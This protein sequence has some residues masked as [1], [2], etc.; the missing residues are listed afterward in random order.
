MFMCNFPSHDRLRSALFFQLAAVAIGFGG[1]ICLCDASL[2]G[3]REPHN[4]LAHATMIRVGEQGIGGLT[5]TNDASFWRVP[6]VDAGDLIFAWVDSRPSPEVNGVAADSFLT[7]LDDSGNPLEFDDNDGPGRSSVIAGL[8]APRSG[9][10]FYRVSQI[11][12]THALVQFAIHHALVNPA[13]SA[14][15]R[16]P[17]DTPAQ[18]E[19]I[20]SKITTGTAGSS[21]VID[22]DHFR[23][24]V[25][26]GDDV[27]VI[28]DADPDQDGI[29]GRFILDIAS[30][31]GATLLAR[32]DGTLLNDANAVGPVE[33]QADGPLLVRIK[34]L[35]DNTGEPLDHDYRF[36]V[37]VR[38]RVYVDSDEDGLENVR[39][40]CPSSPNPDQRDQDGDRTGDA[41]D[42]CPNSPLKSDPGECGCDRPDVDIDGDGQFDCVDD[43]ARVLMDRTGVFIMPSSLQGDFSAYDARDG[44]L[45]D[46]DFLGDTAGIANISG[47]AFDPLHRRLIAISRGDRLVQIGLEDRSHEFFTP[48]GAPEGL[49]FDDAKGVIVLPD[50][51]VLVASTGGPNGNAIVELDGGGQLIQ[52]RVPSGSE[53]TQPVDLLSSPTELLVSDRS[54]GRIARFDIQ[55]GAGLSDLASVSGLLNRLSRR[56][57]GNLLAAVSNG[58][59]RGII[60]FSADG[61]RLLHLAPHGISFF[62][63]AVELADQSQLVSAGPGLIVVD[64]TGHVTATRDRRFGPSEFARVLFDADQDGIG[65]SIDNCQNTA[66]PDQADVNGNRIGDVCE[67]IVQPGETPPPP[68]GTTPPNPA[69]NPLPPLFQPP[70]GVFGSP[71]AGFCGAGFAPLA[72]LLA[73]SMMLARSD[74]SR[75]RSGRIPRRL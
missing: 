61:E 66:N 53:I 41:C 62:R 38:D 48:P 35:R 24:D 10:A 28:F 33:A 47:L 26:S 9:N 65:D 25:R 37:L 60:E 52:N 54:S 22:F 32:G 14:A 63:F 39:D 67:P 44:K 23:I 3:Q 21:D 40:N 75:H 13:D 64:R 17:N 74:G 68:G 58:A 49:L 59:D 8:V 7:V 2:V 11:G 71:P 1:R 6:H 20:R 43:P 70:S 18:A 72:S 16:E 51:H 45:L 42:G 29:R 69:G 56:P 57:N 4:A 46:T 5:A 27:V 15:E 50:G 73:V 12:G 31:D 19:L 30:A 34:G 55:T 36:V